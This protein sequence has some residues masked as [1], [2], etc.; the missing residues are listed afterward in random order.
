[1]T[2]MKW[3]R[4]N[5]QKLMAIVVVV[6]MVGFIGGSALVRS[7]ENISRSGNPVVAYYGQNEK[8]RESDVTEAREELSILRDLKVDSLMRSISIPLLQ[9]NSLQ[10]VALGEV[11]F[12]E[13][14]GTSLT[15]AMLKQARQNYGLNITDKQIYDLMKSTEQ[16]YVYWILLKKEAQA[17]G[18]VISKQQ[19]ELFLNQYIPTFFN[20]A[21]YEQVVNAFVSAPLSAERMP[22]SRKQI[23]SAFSNLMSVLE[24]GR[25]FCL[26]EDVTGLQIE[27]MVEDEMQTLDVNYVRFNSDV[28]T[29]NAPEPSAEALNRQFD[30]YK[31]NYTGELSKENPYGF[32]YKVPDCAELQY[33]VIRM[34]DVE[35]IAEKPTQQDMEKYYNQYKPYLTEKVRTDPNDS[36]SPEMDRTKTF[37]EVA[38]SI[39]KTLMVQRVE[40]K[41]N[42]IIQ[43]AMSLAENSE[44]SSKTLT[45]QEFSKIANNYQTISQQIRKEFNIP[46]IWGQTGLLSAYEMQ[47][48]KIIGKL[49]IKGPQFDQMRNPSAEMLYRVV[50]AVEQLGTS[51]IDTVNIPRPVLYKTIGP[52]DDLDGKIKVIVRIMEVQKAGPPS[53]LE[54]IYD[55]ASIVTEPNSRQIKIYSVKDGVIKDLKKLEVLGTTK[56]TAEDFMREV[57]KIDNWQA[58]VDELNKQYPKGPEK[59]PEESNNFAF[60]NLMDQRQIPETRVYTIELYAQGEPA[61]GI[62][63]FNVLKQRLFLEQLFALSKSEPNGP[64]TPLV[65]EFAGDMSYYC[66]K[67]I[68]LNQVYDNQYL[69]QKVQ[70]MYYEDIFRSQGLALVFYN[71]DNILKRNNFRWQTAAKTGGPN[72][73]NL[74]KR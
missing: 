15:A 59:A 50:F 54:Q 70:R 49:V 55:K 51:V 42:Q 28:F 2:L 30:T 40:S 6:L 19:T 48:D 35:K 11:L 7:C 24:F 33:I 27:N 46:C 66:I 63:L 47:K 8:I 44:G 37:A 1:M 45:E 16:P 74:L 18:L 34:A 17:G 62:E 13:K 36:N 5:N 43:R 22:V 9:T 12:G 73:V 23:V 31:N 61:L 39:E 10:G 21:S 29:K 69:S 71:P 65:W 41:S 38:D 32:G 3:F 57:E 52:V 67:N 26:T 4:K 58:K 60:V 56:K 64:K 25:F 68:S 53:A 14:T 20:G 72:D